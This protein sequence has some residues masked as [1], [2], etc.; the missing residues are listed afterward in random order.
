[1]VSRSVYDDN[2]G[3]CCGRRG[4]AAGLCERV[5]DRD[6]RRVV[7]VRLEQRSVDGSFGITSK[8]FL[9]QLTPSGSL[10]DSLEVPNSSQRG[11]SSDGIRWSRASR[12]KSEL[13]LNLSTD[14]RY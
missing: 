10:V 14:G 7:S 8:I 4:L 3:E 13:A 9:D 12:S 1:M 5:C 6:S 2:A 11:V